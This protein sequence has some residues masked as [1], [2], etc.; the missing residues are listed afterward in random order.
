VPGARVQK[1]DFDAARDRLLATGAFQNAG[2]EFKPSAAGSGYDATVEVVEEPQFFA[3]RFEGLPLS[4]EALRAT[5]RRLEPI[6]EDRIPPGAAV[7]DRFAKAIQRATGVEVAGGLVAD[8]PGEPVILFRPPAPQVN[9]AEVRFTG[10]E[11]LPSTAL[12]QAISTVAVG[13]AYSETA[14]RQML[15]T[16]VRPLYEARGR[17]RVEFPRI[18]TQRAEKV[19]GV[20]VTVAV[21]EGAAFK[22]GSVR[23]AGVAPGLA[24][25]IEKAANFR[26][27]D[28]ANFDDIQAGVSRV[29]QRYLAAGFLKHA[30]HVERDIR[31]QDATVHLAIRVDAGPQYFMGKLRIQGL[32]ILSEPAVRKMWRLEEGK[33]FQAQY[34]DAFLARVRE[35][36]LFDNLGKTRAETSIDETTRVVDVTLYFSGAAA[37]RATD[38]RK[39]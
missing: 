25:E 8:L 22:L 9:V 31:D 21:R 29:H 4:E 23:W 30:A 38:A 18:A 20:V 34:P 14:F 10:N 37:D 16:S 36:D 12:M 26:T 5:L 32:D 39:K 15:D 11:V 19:N 24:A 3:Y 6:F 35:E 7:L 1:A 27:E 28:I 17:I 33:P 2:Y 13:R